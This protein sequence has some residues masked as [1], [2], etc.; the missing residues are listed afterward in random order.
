MFVMGKLI[1]QQADLIRPR[2]VTL[3]SEI[4]DTFHSR[5]ARRSRSEMMLGKVE[6]S[7]SIV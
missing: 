4:E 7:S 2:I 3:S 1:I 5:H 6:V